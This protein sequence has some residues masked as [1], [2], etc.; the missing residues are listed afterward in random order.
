MLKRHGPHPDGGVAQLVER[1]T[2]T[3]RT[4]VQYPSAAKDFSPRVNFQCRLSY[5]VHTP[6]CAIECMNICAHVKYPVVHVRVP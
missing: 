5:S 3:L 2:G 4:E 6:Q 1:W